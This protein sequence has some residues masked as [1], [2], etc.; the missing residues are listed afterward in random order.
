[1]NIDVLMPPI[2]SKHYS[3][4]TDQTYAGGIPSPLD[5]LALNLPSAE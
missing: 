3:L 2:R 4:N 1:M 5:S